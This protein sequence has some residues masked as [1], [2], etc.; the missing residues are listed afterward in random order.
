VSG[1]LGG[2]ALAEAMALPT[3]LSISAI[4]TNGQ[5]EGGGSY[6]MISR[7]LGPEL[8]GG[9]GILFYLAC[10]FQS[11]FHSAPSA[12]PSPQSRFHLCSLRRPISF[13][14]H[15]NRARKKKR[16]HSD[17][18]WRRLKLYGGRAPQHNRSSFT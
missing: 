14:H 2:V 7:S 13:R 10:V 11:R 3:V 12:H 6:F 4:A 15:D 8:G 17:A 18:A 5:M 16:R 1:I 9:I